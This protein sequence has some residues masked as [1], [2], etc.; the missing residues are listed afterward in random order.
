MLTQQDIDSLPDDPAD[1]FA[2]LGDL[3]EAWV[4]LRQADREGISPVE[5]VRCAE[6]IQAVVAAP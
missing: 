1:A 4:E 5:A 2:V 3:F 6:D